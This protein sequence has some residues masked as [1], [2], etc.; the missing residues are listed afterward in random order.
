MKNNQ[1]LICTKDL[2]K[3]TYKSNAFTKGKIYEVVS[4]DENIIY[5]LDNKK[6]EFNFSKNYGHWLHFY[7]IKDYF[8]TTRTRRKK[9]EKILNNIK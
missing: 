3:S 4:E 8:D 7:C 1:T 9:I 2:Y 6:R 5:L